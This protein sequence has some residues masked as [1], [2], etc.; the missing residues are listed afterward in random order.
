MAT[1]THAR[2]A[3]VSLLYAFSCGNGDIRKYA[4]EMLLERKI[5]NAQQGFALGLFDGIV[6][7]LSEV[8]SLIQATLKG[9]E[10]ERISVIDKCIIRLGTYEMRFLGLDAAIAINEALEI[11]KMLGGE[12]S[13][14]FVNGILDAIAKHKIARDSQD[15]G[16]SQGLADSRG[17]EDLKD[18]KDSADS[19]P[20]DLPKTPQ[21]F[22]DS[23]RKTAKDSRFKPQNAAKIRTTSPKNHAKND[24]KN[25]PVNPKNSPKN[26]AANP[27]P[28][29]SKNNKNPQK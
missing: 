9:W 12:H 4:P 7:R 25:R 20:K 2:E 8:D 17:R 5:R 15:F 6:G 28:R 18:S 22:E 1:R 27:R 23:P 24:P 14:R 11:A 16:D 21:G 10:I 13:V 3:V 19:P 26:N 29:P